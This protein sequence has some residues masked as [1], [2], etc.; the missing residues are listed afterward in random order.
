MAIFMLNGQAMDAAT[1]WLLTWL[2]GLVLYCS[3][4]DK[5]GPVNVFAERY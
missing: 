1:G 5:S 3:D 2:T 4:W